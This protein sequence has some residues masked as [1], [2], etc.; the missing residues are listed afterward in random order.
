MVVKVTPVTDKVAHPDGLDFA[1]SA[2]I[3]DLLHGTKD[4]H[5]A[6]VKADHQP[7]P[8]VAPRL[9]DVVTAGDRDGQRLLTEDM[10]ACLQGS[11]RVFL[12]HI[13]GRGHGNG[14]DVRTGEQFA[15]VAGDE[16][17]PAV[18][19]AEGLEFDRVDVRAAHNH[20]AA[21]RVVPVPPEASAAAYSYHADPQLCVR[22]CSSIAL[23]HLRRPRA[24]PARATCAIMAARRAAGKRGRPACSGRPVTDSV[25]CTGAGCGPCL[26]RGGRRQANAA[27]GATY[28]AGRR[29]RSLLPQHDA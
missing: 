17:A 11:H 25:L 3:H 27:D 5:V 24:G 13:V 9:Q 19:L 26:P 23:Q 28:R 4:V 15:V 21:R 1:D 22:H 20:R 16:R 10:L 8:M 18:L 2:G 14:V 12:V 7:L 29:R 6:H